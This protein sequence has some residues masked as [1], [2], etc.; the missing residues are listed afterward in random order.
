MAQIRK[1]EANG[2]LYLSSQYSSG[3]LP[4]MSARQ[5]A[6]RKQGTS[7][8]KQKINKK[9]QK[10]RLVSK[11]NANFISGRDL[12]VCL[13]FREPPGSERSCLQHFHEEVKER[14][15]AIGL[16]HGYICV[17]ETH[18]ME[19]VP[20][21][22]H[23]HLF[24][25]GAHGAGMYQKLCQIIADAW[26]YGMADVRILDDGGD[27]FEDTV[28]YLL[29]QKRSKG[30]RAY[31]CSRN[32]KP[33]A[34][35][36]R[37]RVAEDAML[38]TPPGVKVIRYEVDANEFCRFAFCVG[39]IVDHAAFDTY[40]KDARRRAAPDPWERIRRRKYRLQ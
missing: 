36:I 24:M 12:F 17:R 27:F 20:V 8:A 38:E 30:E 23:Y 29:K 18:S 11:A 37:R 39:R 26:P 1:E 19:D 35:P 28:K 21:N 10:W 2:S 33:A 7:E 40:W 31:S 25:W 3:M 14:Y 34:E 13:T 4:G 16:Q 32:L 22:L 5:R 9:D 15:K 6:G